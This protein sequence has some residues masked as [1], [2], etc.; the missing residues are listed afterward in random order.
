MH[1]FRTPS[2]CEN[3]IVCKHLESIAGDIPANVLFLCSEELQ[4]NGK[5]VCAKCPHFGAKVKPAT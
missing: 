1:D 5:S 2:N 4:L 3:F